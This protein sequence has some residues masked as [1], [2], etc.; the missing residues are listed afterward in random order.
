MECSVNVLW[1]LKP[2]LY[3]QIDRLEATLGYAFT[4]KAWLCEA[5]THRS[6][7]VTP[8]I[9]EDT[10]VQER[11]WNERLEFLG[12]SVLGLTITEH[13]SGLKR[14]LSEGDMSRIRAALVCEDSLARLAREKLNL[15]R[16]LILGMSEERSAGREKSS[17]LADAVEA[18]IG[19]VFSDGGWIPART[20]VLK[21]YDALLQKGFDECLER[22]HKTVLQEFAQAKF[23]RAPTYDVLAENGP[24]HDRLFEVAVYLNQD[25]SREEWGRGSGKTKK[26]AAQMAALQALERLKESHHD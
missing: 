7:L 4:N 8:G 23:H 3:S 12:D 15:G 24:A 14:I 5:L 19:A 20:L 21:L 16:Y 2:E 10:L 9:D 22:D 17:L 25:G 18:V 6:A 13:L 11:R 26:R 1:E